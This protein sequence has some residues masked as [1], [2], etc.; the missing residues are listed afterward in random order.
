MESM[1]SETKNQDEPELPDVYQDRYRRIIRA[2]RAWPQLPEPVVLKWIGS[3]AKFPDD[4]EMG[5]EMQN[6]VGLDA[7]PPTTECEL[8]AGLWHR[9]VHGPARLPASGKE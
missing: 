2:L 7:I 4:W 6:E 8:G 1:T 5:K 3:A 9:M